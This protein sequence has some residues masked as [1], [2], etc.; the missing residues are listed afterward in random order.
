MTNEGLSTEARMLKLV[1][2]LHAKTQAGE[3]QWER[4]AYLNNFQS[5]FPSYVV[6]VSMK[7]GEADAGPD[8][9][10]AIRDQEGTLIE[11]AGDAD[12]ERAV[13]NSRAFVL[14][15][16]LYSMARRQAL[17]VNQA[18]DSLLSELE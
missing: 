16:E 18:L 9:Y 11:R 3:L 7:Q 8:Y 15:G 1:R 17:G 13:P 12:I 4:T 5:S 6:R 10:V 2:L 14:M